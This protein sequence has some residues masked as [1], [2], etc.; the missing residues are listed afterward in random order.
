MGVGVLEA[1]DQQVAAKVDLPLEVR[2][3]LRRGAHMGDAPAVDPDLILRYAHAAAEAERA[4]VEKADHRVFPPNFA[5]ISS[6]AMRSSASS[7]GASS[8]APYF[9]SSAVRI[10]RS[11]KSGF[12]GSRGPWL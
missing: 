5:H 11:A 2:Q 6:C 8:T 7:S 4:A 9:R 12:F 3:R 10:S 1:G